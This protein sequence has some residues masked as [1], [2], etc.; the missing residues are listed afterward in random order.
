[1]HPNTLTYACIPFLYEF[2]I[3]YEIDSKH[4]LHSSCACHLVFKSDFCCFIVYLSVVLLTDHHSRINRNSVFITTVCAWSPI[5]WKFNVY[6]FNNFIRCLVCTYNLQ[7][8]YQNFWI[9]KKSVLVWLAILIVHSHS[10][11]SFPYKINKKSRSMELD[12]T[13]L[14]IQNPTA[15]RNM[16]RSQTEIW[17]FTI[18]YFP[19]LIYK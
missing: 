14:Q 16:V 10:N 17:C 7:S 13:C 4:H 2:Y 15:K 1:M 12:L 5:Q 3:T 18:P 6:L 9:Q 19:G 8:E 11:W